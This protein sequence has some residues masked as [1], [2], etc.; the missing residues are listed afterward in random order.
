MTQYISDLLRELQRNIK[1][2]YDILDTILAPENSGY[3]YI[4]LT[5]GG[6]DSHD[7][8]D[9]PPYVTN[10]EESEEENSGD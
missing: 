10:E 5:R 2:I 3:V 1:N 9:I 6:E 7:G 4:D 8:H